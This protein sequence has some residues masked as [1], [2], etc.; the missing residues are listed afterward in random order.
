M[1]RSHAGPRPLILLLALGA[2]LAVCSTAGAH[3]HVSPPVVLANEGQV[4]T[5]AVPTEKEDATTTTIEL[6][7]PDGFSIDSFADAPGWTRKVDKQ[8]SGEDAVVEK[9]TWS[10]GN[11]PAGDAAMFQ[12]LGSTDAAKTYEFGV[13]QTYSD[14]EVVDWSGSESSDTPAPTIEATDS[15]GGGGGGSSTLDIVAIVL[16][17][18]A[19]VVAGASLLT[20]GGKRSLA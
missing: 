18:V 4:F 5:L 7:P 15:L 11:V 9:V 1:N 8:G 16:A 12:F 20:R 2:A 10:G 19:L 13:R 14:G 3:A 6:T 17:A